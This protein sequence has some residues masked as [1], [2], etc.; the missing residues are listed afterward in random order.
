MADLNLKF[1]N[2]KAP[3]LNAT[4]MNAIVDAINDRMPKTGI[5][6]DDWVLN[7]DEVRIGVNNSETAAWSSVTNE[8]VSVNSNRYDDSGEEER[9]VIDGVEMKWNKLEI[10][11]LYGVTTMTPNSI[12][13]EFVLPQFPDGKKTIDISNGDIVVQNTNVNMGSLYMYD[14]VAQ[15]VKV[16]QNKKDVTTIKTDLSKLVTVDKNIEKRV[17]NLEYASQGILYR[18]D[19]DDS[20]AITKSVDNG[21]LPYASLDVIGAKSVVT[22]SGIKNAN[23]KEIVS[24]SKNG[25]EISKIDVSTLINK[26]FPNSMKSAGN[27]S[28]VIDLVN[29]KAIKKVGSVD[30]GTLEWIY[31]STIN[32]R[33]MIDYYCSNNSSNGIAKATVPMYSI[34]TTNRI[35]SNVANNYSL[36]ITSNAIRLKNRDYNNASALKTA[37][38]GVILNFELRDY[39]ETPIS[40]EDIEKFK[41]LTVEGG[42]TLYFKTLDEFDVAI[43]TTE[44]FAIKTGG[45]N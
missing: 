3:A 13:S 28:D 17:T 30:L 43:P 44:T 26:Y 9:I 34:D 37:L 11:G 18:A 40:D 39:I 45:A 42:G 23:L 10:K 38:S 6:T 35:Y 25:T 29:K 24:K 33:A 2:G 20:E 41:Y 14:L 27:V 36:G 32:F 12:H 8:S 31:D 19:V 1:E 5:W 15:M 16:D 22:D 4:N 7:K 21:A